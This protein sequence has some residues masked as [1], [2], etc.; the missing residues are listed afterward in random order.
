MPIL[1]RS[2]LLVAALL[3]PLPALAACAIGEPP[4]VP[5]GATAAPAEMNQARGL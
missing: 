2:A 5:D 1:I 4:P 3:L